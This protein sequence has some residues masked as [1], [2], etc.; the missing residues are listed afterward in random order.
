MKIILLPTACE[1]A[2]T[3]QILISTFIKKAIFFL[4][5][6]FFSIETDEKPG[7]QCV[8]Y[9]YNSTVS[10]GF[11]IY[12]CFSKYSNET[13]FITDGY[14][15]EELILKWN[16]ELQFAFG[17]KTDSGP[18]DFYIQEA[19]TVEGVT[20]YKYI[21]GRKS[22]RNSCNNSLKLLFFM[23]DYLMHYP[24]QYATV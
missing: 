10:N 15:E 16:D 12:K 11:R 8:E 13:W 4:R 17:T 24:D 18:T 14:S 21:I 1:N 2:R 3:E 5:I 9:K 23:N 6:C 7:V 22:R 20:Q 19:S